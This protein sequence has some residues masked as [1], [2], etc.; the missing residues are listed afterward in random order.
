MRFQLFGLY[1]AYKDVGYNVPAE[2]QDFY[3][4]EM[5]KKIQEIRVETARTLPTPEEPF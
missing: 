1:N 3:E 4:A 2:F 5:D